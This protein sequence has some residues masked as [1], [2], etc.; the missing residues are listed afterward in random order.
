MINYVVI[1]IRA[2]TP[3]RKAEPDKGNVWFL[4]NLP[5]KAIYKII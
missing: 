3:V 5:K 2:Q 1:L 4:R